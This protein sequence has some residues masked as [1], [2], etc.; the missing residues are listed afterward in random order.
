VEK[1]RCRGSIK[2]V[3]VG[4]RTGETREKGRRREE[5]RVEAGRKRA[6]GLK[7]NPKSK[8]TKS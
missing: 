2:A 5:L 7:E 8:H 3:S 1:G 6:K 4:R